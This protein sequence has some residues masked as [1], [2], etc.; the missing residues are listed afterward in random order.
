MPTRLTNLEQASLAPST[1]LSLF[2]LDAS[3]LGGPT[4]YFYDGTNMN[5]TS[6]VFNGVSYMGLPLQVEGFELDGKG[7]LP[8][9]K[10]RCANLNGLVSSYLLA[11]DDLAGAKVIRRRVFARF[12]DNQNFPNNKNPYGSPDPTAAYPDDIFYVNRKVTENKQYVEFELATSLEIDNVK[13]PNRQI[14]AGI[15]S[16]KYRDPETCGYTGIPIADKN[17]NFFSAAP[18]SFASLYNSGLWDYKWT[19]KSGDYVYTISQNPKTLGDQIF[20]I[21]NANNVSG[22]GNNPAKNMSNWIPDLCSKRIL[23]CRCRYPLPQDLRFGGFPGVSRSP[24]NS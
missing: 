14:L 23:G 5:Y 13:L 4:L 11:N 16:F 6:V 24:Y 10:L 3:F 17:N 9:P 7:T 1:L 8:R 22:S 2:I 20:F 19:Y 12:I 21:C 18:Y 15:C